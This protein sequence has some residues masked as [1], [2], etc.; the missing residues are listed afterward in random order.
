MKKL[1]HKLVRDRRGGYHLVFHNS[2]DREFIKSTIQ[3]VLCASL[4]L[5][6]LWSILI[7]T[8]DSL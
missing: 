6:L 4:Y 3:V 7:I 2:Y 8:P 1:T 5:F